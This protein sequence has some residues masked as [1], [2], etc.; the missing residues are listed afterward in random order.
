MPKL[1]AYRISTLQME[2]ARFFWGSFRS[3]TFWKCIYLLQDYL[4]GNPPFGRWTNAV[5][6]HYSSILRD[7]WRLRK[8]QSS[9]QWITLHPLLFPPSNIQH[10]R[11]IHTFSNP[12]Y[13]EESNTIALGDY[14]VQRIYLH[15][16]LLCYHIMSPGI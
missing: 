12:F 2:N 16:Q 9:D 13:S 1:K 10:Y 15:K 6:S 8:R 7:I 14:R 3:S 5:D 4:S 11:Y